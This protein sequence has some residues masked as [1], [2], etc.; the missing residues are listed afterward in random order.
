MAS[1]GANSLN[2]LNEIVKINGRI[3]QGAFERETIHF[4]VKGKNNSPS[5]W[6]LH[7]KMTA[8]TM[9][10]NESHALE[11]RQNLLSREEGEL[12][13]VNSTTS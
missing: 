8:F 2:I 11:G 7:L 12:H 13:T 6:M 4:R 9:D 3:P 10:F 5:V 1:K